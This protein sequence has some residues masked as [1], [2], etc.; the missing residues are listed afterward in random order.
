MAQSA[1]AEALM[2][3]YRRRLLAAGY[4]EVSPGVFSMSNGFAPQE[5]TMER[6]WDEVSGKKE[7][8]VSIEITPVE[9][10]HEFG[11]KVVEGKKVLKTGTAPSR[12]AAKKSA[13]NWLRQNG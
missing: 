2:A 11:W 8:G 3:E 12:Y 5:G 13:N 6:I 7:E 4:V 10:S 9:G 1:N